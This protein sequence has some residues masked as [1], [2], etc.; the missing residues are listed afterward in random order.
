MLQGDAVSTVHL[1]REGWVKAVQTTSSGREVLVALLGP[2]DAIGHFEAF[3]G[4][5]ARHWATVI[6]LEDTRTTYVPADRFLEYL[7]DHPEAALVQ[8]RDLVARLGRVDRSRLEG[9][10]FD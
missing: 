2:D 1:I 9:A 7:H 10:L 5:G 3:E 6:A 8:L 4:L